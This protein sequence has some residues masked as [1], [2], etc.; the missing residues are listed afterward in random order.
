MTA[1]NIE[2]KPWEI[3]M[4]LDETVLQKVAEW[5]PTTKERSTLTVPDVGSGWAVTL[6]ADRCDEVGCLLWEMDLRRTAPT[7]SSNT[8]RAWADQIA[9][10]ARGLMESLQ[11]V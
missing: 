3:A 1:R 10:R 7:S 8:L 4:T 11:V 6:Q 2:C 9:A 5:R